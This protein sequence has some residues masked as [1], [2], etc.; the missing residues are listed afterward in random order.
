L[1]S[2]ASN[3]KGSASNEGSSNLPTNIVLPSKEN[4]NIN[5]FKNFNSQSE[6]SDSLF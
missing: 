6:I 5:T 2:L 1:P 4:V 3:L